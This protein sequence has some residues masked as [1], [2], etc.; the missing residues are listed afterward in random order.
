MR[1]WVGLY[2]FEPRFDENEK[3][4]GLFV[5]LKNVGSLPAQKAHLVVIIRPCKLHEGEQP[6]PARSERLEQKALMPTEDGNYGV[7]LA[8]YPQIQTWVADRRDIAIEGTFTYALGPKKFKST[9]QAELWFSRPKPQDK[10]VALNW[11]N[12]DAT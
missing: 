8:P 2:N 7:L 12:T 10:P 9:F 4:A 6:N 11:R 3:L 1:P 5:L